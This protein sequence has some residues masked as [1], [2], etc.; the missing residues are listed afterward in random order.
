MQKI[1]IK[2]LVEFRR[3]TTDKARKNFADKL[4]TRT[5]KEKKQEDKNSGGGN[6]W[7]TSTSAIYNVFKHNKT[8]F[9]EEK[10]NEL[11]TKLAAKDD[12]KVRGMYQRNIDIL[13][14]FKD[15]NFSEFRP[16]KIVKFETV[17]R[18]HTLME[19]SDLPLYITPD[20]L[21][22]HERKGKTEIG[23]IWLVAQINGFKK[24]ELG[25]FCEMLHEFLN[26]HFA[27]N[28]QIS[29]DLCIAIDTFNAQK[30]TY[31]ELINEDIPFLIEKT[32]KEIIDL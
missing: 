2:E 19:V 9:Y 28:Y 21:F 18:M 24:N 31:Q 4:K 11:V 30:V 13:N 27:E 6:Y 29:D 25:M 3:K 15:F 8:H 7:V 32:I 26:K 5:K 14:N 1:N 22:V 10:I 17:Q 12:K 20:L 23:A 16:A